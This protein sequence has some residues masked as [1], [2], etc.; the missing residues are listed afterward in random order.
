M[1]IYSL[2]KSD[3]LQFSSL[4]CWLYSMDIT[5]AILAPFNL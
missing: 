2:Q 5:F 4:R 3:I 1:F